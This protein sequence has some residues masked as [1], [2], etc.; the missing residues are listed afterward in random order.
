[1]QWIS[2]PSTDIEPMCNNCWIYAHGNCARRCSTQE[3]SI[4]F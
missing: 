4:R 1:M 2:E 3:C